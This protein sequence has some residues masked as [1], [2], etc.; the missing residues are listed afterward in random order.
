MSKSEKGMGWSVGRSTKNPTGY[1]CSVQEKDCDAWDG[2]GVSEL[3][4]AWLL[5]LTG[6]STAVAATLLALV[7]CARTCRTTRA[8]VIVVLFFGLQGP[9]RAFWVGM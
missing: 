5:S 2:V 6:V 8:E 4:G 1:H 3:S 7:D 9:L